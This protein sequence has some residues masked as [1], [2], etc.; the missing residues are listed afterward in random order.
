M[1]GSNTEFA[2]GTE[3]T[4]EESKCGGQRGGSL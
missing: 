1:V 2:E 4:E 3:K